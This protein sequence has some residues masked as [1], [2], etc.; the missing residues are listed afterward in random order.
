M[1]FN[2]F[3]REKSEREMLT[4]LQ[5]AIYCSQPY[6]I[7]EDLQIEKWGCLARWAENNHLPV[8][9]SLMVSSEDLG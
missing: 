4:P 2:A 5:I 8:E 1:F 3:N 7:T 9:I 6:F